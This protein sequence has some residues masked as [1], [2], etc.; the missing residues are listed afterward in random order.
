MG[1]DIHVYTEF[2][3]WYG[4][5]AGE[6]FSADNYRL[7][8][9]YG[10]DEDEKKYEVVPIY[11]SRNYSLFSILAGVRNYGNN[12]P[13]SEPKGLPEDCCEE[14][15]AEYKSW[16][17][18]GH[19]HSYFTLKELLD[20]QKRQPLLKHSGYVDKEA[21]EKLDEG[22]TPDSWWQGGNVPGQVWREWEEKD[23]SLKKFVDA[24]IEREKDIFWIFSDNQE[25]IEKHAEEIRIVFWFD[26]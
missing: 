11:D 9:H 26:N 4:K 23:T 19:S 3:L 20:Y 2:K 14:I 15:K 22:I 7:N 1:C 5:R 24:I 10:S 8:P 12:I 13:I 6:W 17:C 18:D 21:S 25:A 16:D